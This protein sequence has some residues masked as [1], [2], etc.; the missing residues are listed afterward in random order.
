[1]IRGVEADR[2]D[3]DDGQES[4]PD[5]MLA[6]PETSVEEWLR[7][8][9]IAVVWEVREDRKMW[10]VGRL[11]DD[12][13][14]GELEFMVDHLTR[15]DEECSKSWKRPERDELMQVERVQVLG[16]VIGDWE[17]VGRKMYF[18]VAN[19]ERMD[20]MLMTHGVTN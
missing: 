6:E 5:I 20:E 12:I 2:E 3:T 19:W 8:E 18:K 9:W 15:V 14:D 7:G 10:Y 17:E 11:V 1:M 16:R 4:L 13:K